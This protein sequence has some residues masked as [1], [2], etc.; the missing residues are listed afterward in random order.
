MNKQA[1]FI[2]IVACIVLLGG[3]AFLLLSPQNLS[4][5]TQSVSAKEVAPEIVADGTTTSS[6]IATLHFQ[7][8]GKIVGLYVKEGDK[9][10]A[11]QIIAQLDA[12]PLQQQLTAQLNAYRS[13]RDTFDQTHADKQ[14]LPLNDTMR[15][16]FDQSQATLD[17]ATVNVALSNYALQLATLSSPISGIVTHEDITTANVNITPLTT[18]IVEDP[19]ALVFRANIPQY[20]IDYIHVGSPTIFTLDGTS[21]KYA[22]TISKIY[23]QKITLPNG[24]QVYQVDIVSDTLSANNAAFDQTGSVT[25]TSDVTRG[26]FLVPAW[27][28]VNHQYVWVEEDGKA[29]LKHVTVGPLHGGDVEIRSGLQTDD[30]IITNPKAIAQKKYSLL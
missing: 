6:N 8:G 16:L 11:G 19:Q 13:T 23:P 14:D 12:Y 27:S 26:V 1:V 2:A 22:G 24:Q 18:F 25:I 5:Q 21:K 30:R 3:L 10:Y 9:V 17:N 28:V 20:Q 4:L 29:M 15:R 7:T